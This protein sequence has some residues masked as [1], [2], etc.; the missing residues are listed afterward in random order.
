MFPIA[1]SG[2]R[3]FGFGQ[4]RERGEPGHPRR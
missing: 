2:E 4:L 3:V 1:L